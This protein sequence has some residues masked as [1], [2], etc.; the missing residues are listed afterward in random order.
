MSTWQVIIIIL[1]IIL[2]TVEYGEKYSPIPLAEIYTTA[3][4]YSIIWQYTSKA[5]E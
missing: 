3:S 4:L 5:C 1:M 2:D